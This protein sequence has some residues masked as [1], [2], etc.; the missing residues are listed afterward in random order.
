[1]YPKP[2]E[3]MIPKRFFIR[4]GDVLMFHSK[5]RKRVVRHLFLFNDRLFV[6][7][8]KRSSFAKYT[9]WLKIDISLRVSGIDIETMQTVSHNNEFRVHLPAKRSYIFYPT[10]SEDRDAWISDIIKSMKG[11]HPGDSVFQKK[12]ER[13]KSKVEEEV[14]KQLKKNDLKVVIN[15]K[16]SEASSQ[17]HTLKPIDRTRIKNR[18]HTEAASGRNRKPTQIDHQPE[19]TEDTDHKKLA[20]KLLPSKSEM[21]TKQTKRTKIGTVPP[22]IIYIAVPV[23]E[24]FRPSSPFNLP[25]GGTDPFSPVLGGPNQSYFTQPTT[26]IGGNPFTAY[27]AQQQQNTVSGQPSFP[28]TI[29]IQ[30]PYPTTNPFMQP[31]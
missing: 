27:V 3:F 13:A 25:S 12:V 15:D 4:E 9:D 14:K 24:P 18:V 23:I 26:Q 28:P 19:E 6:T 21:K 5:K 22:K 30:P 17:E 2:H 29:Q 8:R 16:E 7:K 31:A 1:L 20:P 10:T 11:E